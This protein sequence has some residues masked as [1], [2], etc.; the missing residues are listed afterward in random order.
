VRRNEEDIGLRCQQTADP[1]LS[2]RAAAD[3]DDQAAAKAQSYG[4][5]RRI[6]R[7]MVAGVGPH[8]QL[9]PSQ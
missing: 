2:D 1:S 5:D 9:T 3:D 7:S 8:A 6:D 4:I